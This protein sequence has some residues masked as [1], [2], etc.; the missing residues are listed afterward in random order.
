MT[1]D[2]TQFGSVQGQLGRRPETL[3][4]TNDRP[5]PLGTH[6]GGHPRDGQNAARARIRDWSRALR[7]AHEP[8]Q[9]GLAPGDA[10]EGEEWE[11][12]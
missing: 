3:P 10:W 1:L 2:R 5:H 8:L 6:N 7:L 4:E 11:G 9:L 12:R